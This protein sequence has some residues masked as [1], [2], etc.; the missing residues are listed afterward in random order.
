MTLDASSLP[1]VVATGDRRKS[2][3]A[4]RDLLADRLIEA[5]TRE[6][7]TIAKELRN[8][9]AELYSLPG[10]R[11]GSKSDELAARRD[12]RRAAAQGS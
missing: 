7:A 3:E 5:G 11:E 10:E 8:V 9:M 6:A 2:L 4:V 12:R 1:A